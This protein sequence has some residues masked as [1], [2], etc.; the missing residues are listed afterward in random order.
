MPTD[1]VRGENLT[2]QPLPRSTYVDGTAVIV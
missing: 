1:L 2:Q